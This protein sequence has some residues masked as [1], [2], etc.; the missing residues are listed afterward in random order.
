MSPSLVS[1]CFDAAMEKVQQ[2]V[3]VLP[4]FFGLNDRNQ[5][6]FLSHVNAFSAYPVIIA[7]MEISQTMSEQLTV[8]ASSK[9]KEY[10]KSRGTNGMC[11]FRPLKTIDVRSAYHEDSAN[12]E[13]FHD[14]INDLAP[15]IDTDQKMMLTLVTC[16]LDAF[17][18]LDLPKQTRDQVFSMKLLFDRFRL[19]L[20]DGSGLHLPLIFQQAYIVQKVQKV[21]KGYD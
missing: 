21:S 18:I 16:L 15:H 5:A 9:D 19:A 17:N 10:L 7:R 8:M 11:C 4:M 2:C 12:M 20:A 3:K 6:H 14:A 13:E 1:F